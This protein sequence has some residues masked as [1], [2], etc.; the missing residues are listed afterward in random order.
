MHTQ[1]HAEL[2]ILRERLTRLT[3]ELQNKE[4]EYTKLME[5]KTQLRRT[6]ALLLAEKDAKEREAFA[7]K[8]RGKELQKAMSELH[9]Q[10]CVEGYV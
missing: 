9:Q 6:N 5:E 4:K 3:S 2:E 7:E 1:A 10:V 8:E